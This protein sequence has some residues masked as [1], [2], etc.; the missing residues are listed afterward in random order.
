MT[1]TTAAEVTFTSGAHSEAGLG[2]R[3]A[4]GAGGASL[5]LVMMRRTM[6]GSALGR[7][8]LQRQQPC[9]SGLSRLLS[10]ELWLMRD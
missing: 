6:G 10:C 4:A 2:R 8:Q 3:A 5:T 1:F 9:A 7:R